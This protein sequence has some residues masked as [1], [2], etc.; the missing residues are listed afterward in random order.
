LGFDPAEQP[1]A[2]Q[3]GGSDPQAL[4]HPLRLSPCDGKPSRVGST[5]SGPTCRGPFARPGPP[6]GH[7]HDAHPARRRNTP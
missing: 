2:L 5:G 1:V 6:L 7:G 4:A 3:L